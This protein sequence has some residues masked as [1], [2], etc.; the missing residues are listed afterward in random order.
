MQR[1]ASSKFCS[2]RKSPAAISCCF[3]A[4]P[5][6]FHRWEDNNEWA[7]LGNSMKARPAICAH[8]KTSMKLSFAFIEFPHP[9]LKRRFT[10]TFSSGFLLASVRYSAKVEMASNSFDEDDMN[11]HIAESQKG[12]KVRYPVDIDREK[13]EL[14]TSIDECFRLLTLQHSPNQNVNMQEN[15][16]D[17]PN[18]VAQKTFRKPIISRKKRSNVINSSNRSTVKLKRLNKKTAYPSMPELEALAQS[19]LSA[20][21]KIQQKIR[22]LLGMQEENEK[23]QK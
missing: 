10:V 17:Q 4:A 18:S 16:E 8:Y 12:T 21:E 11:D 5:T 1:K 22:Q 2:E 23:A 14:K 13:A 6:R 3:Q 19:F 9:V 20:P 7:Q 15:A